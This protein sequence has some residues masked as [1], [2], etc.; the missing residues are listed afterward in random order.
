MILKLIQLVPENTKIDFFGH[1]FYAMFA[2]LIIIGG[3]LLCVAVKG[4]N[5]GID[6]TGGTVIEIQV[7]EDPNLSALRTELNEL[8]LGDVSLQEFGEKRDLMIRLPQQEGGPEEQQAAI[9]KV[10][11]SLNSHFGEGQVDFRRTEFVGPQVGDELKK[12][13]LLA[14]IFAIMAIMGYIWIRFE[15]Q[16]G[17]GSLLALIHDVVGIIGL[18]SLTQMHFDLSTLAAILLVAGYS[19]NETVIIFDRIR[20]NMRR[21]KKMPMPEI[22][23]LSINNTLPRTVMTSGSTILALLALWLFGGEVIRSFT[24]ALFFGI[25]IG[26][27]SSYFVSSQ[28]LFYLKLRPDTALDKEEDGEEA[29]AAPTK[30]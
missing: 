28:A 22:I 16:Y 26:T 14:I 8:G 3:S 10:Q 6:F 18:F 9:N 24:S 27:H 25:L 29:D 20:E 17:V 11:E 15:W 12:D 1:R 2:S 30:A 21:F 23:N 5:F 7:K 19:I 13:G 4:L